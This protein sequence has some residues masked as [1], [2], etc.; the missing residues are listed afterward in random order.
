[1]LSRGF[2]QGF[3]VVTDRSLSEILVAEGAGIAISAPLLD[4]VSVEVVILVA[5]QDNYHI[6][7]LKVFQTN[8]TLSV[9][10]EFLRIKD[11]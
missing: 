7:L 5:R 10:C 2:L 9:I 3:I 11:L 1:M 4:T 6:P 8:R